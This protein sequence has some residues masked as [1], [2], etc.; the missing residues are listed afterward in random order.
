MTVFA[1]EPR[2][3][4]GGC[5]G[6]DHQLLAAYD[7]LAE[8]YDA[9]RGLFD[10]RAVLEDLFARLPAC[11]TLLDLG[12]GAGEPCARAFLDRGWRVTGVDFCPAMLALAARYVPEM[13]R[14]QADMRAVRLAP[15]RFDAVTAIYS[16]FHVPRRDH[17]ALLARVRDWLRPGGRF[18]FT[19]A[20]RAYTGAK[21]FDGTIEFMGQALFY[22]H[23]TPEE[24]RA[25]AEA[26]GL[27]WEDATPRAIGGETFLWVTLVRPTEGAAPETAAR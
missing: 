11:G 23:A 21:R 26:V 2:I 10:M 22:S 7:A 27:R 16:L 8:T 12:C 19:Y 17:P 6:A 9:H 4:N 13:E 24:L 14:I 1:S 20:T 15:R 18:L 5:M 25:Q 3:V